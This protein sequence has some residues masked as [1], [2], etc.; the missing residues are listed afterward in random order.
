MSLGA[1]SWRAVRASVGP[2]ETGREGFLQGSKRGSH[3]WVGGRE[4]AG[5]QKSQVQHAHAAPQLPWDSLGLTG[6]S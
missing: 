5:L 6:H 2:R 1:P 4:L 3:H